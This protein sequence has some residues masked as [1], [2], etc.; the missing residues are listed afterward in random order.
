MCRVVKQ[1]CK[2]ALGFRGSIFLL[3]VL[4]VA[5]FCSSALLPT[6]PP[7][8]MCGW[9]GVFGCGLWV[10]FRL[11]LEPAIWLLLR[12]PDVTQPSHHLLQLSLQLQD[13]LHPVAGRSAACPFC[14]HQFV[15]WPAS[16]EKFSLYN[17]VSQTNFHVTRSTFQVHVKG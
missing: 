7:S 13:V 3:Q 1:F 17:Y 9:W 4:A 2:G 14:L 6:S 11:C 15:M 8:C 12:V 5:S 10:H 16:V